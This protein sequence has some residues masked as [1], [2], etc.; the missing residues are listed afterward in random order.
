MIYHWDIEQGSDEWFELKRGK[1][2]A[3]KF[4]R[5][6]S[7]K[8]TDRYKGLINKIL[9]ERVSN[10]SVSEFVSPAMRRGTE[11]E[12]EARQK[13]MSKTFNL[14]KEIGFVEVDDLVGVSPD[15]L[16]GANGGLEIK[17][18]EYNA[19]MNFVKTQAIPPDYFWQIQGCLWASEREW[20]DY[21]VYHPDYDLDPLRVYRDEEKIKELEIEIEIAKETITEKLNKISKLNEA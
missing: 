15:G 11:L 10:T 20:W 17:C 9:F 19:L 18:L 16:V 3:S 4:G 2:S 1:L 21:F 14:V 13:Y 7:K 6:F 12:P 8:T 5:L